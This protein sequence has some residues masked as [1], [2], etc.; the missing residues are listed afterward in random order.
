MQY[1]PHVSTQQKRDETKKT[2]EK[3][4]EKE[5]GES[6]CDGETGDNAP[7]AGLRVAP[8]RT[9]QEGEKKCKG[10]KRTS[11]YA[12]GRRQAKP[13]NKHSGANRMLCR[14]VLLAR[15]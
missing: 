2:K 9:V 7:L 10:Q 15:A 11:R 13:F 12:V 3:T 5:E 4:R 14:I 8:C 6:V 1:I